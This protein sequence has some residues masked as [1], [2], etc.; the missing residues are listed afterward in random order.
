MRLIQILIIGISI[1]VHAQDSE[2][3]LW[4]NLYPS[5]IS[6][7]DTTVIYSSLTILNTEIGLHERE[8]GTILKLKNT[9][10][11]SSITQYGY[12]NFKESKIKICIAQPLSKSIHIG[13]NINYHHLYIT[14][15]PNFN[16]ISFDLG[17]GIKREK[18]EIYLFLQNPL[19]AAYLQNDIESRFTLCPVYW[20][21]KNLKSELRLTESVHSGISIHHKLSYN[22]QNLVQL[23]IIQ[24]LKPFEYGINLGYKK[25]KFQFFSQYYKYS[26]SHSTSF[27][28][29]YTLGNG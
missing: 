11:G 18:V 8:L 14:D 27:L 9:V 6:N 13:L 3:L 26:Y 17:A 24:G 10:F 25:K 2:D 5:L 22:Y 15:S 7:F 12:K 23:S 28:I 29:I 19:N 20:W 21:N 4:N 1:F 16:A